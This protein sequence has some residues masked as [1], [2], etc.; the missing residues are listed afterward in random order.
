VIDKY[1]KDNVKMH[2]SKF[3]NLYYGPWPVEADKN[4]KTAMELVCAGREE[5]VVRLHAI[6][7][8]AL[9]SFDPIVRTTL[10]EEFQWQGNQD[11]HA[12]LSLSDCDIIYS[13][14]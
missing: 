8:G 10:E 1:S 5:L 9:R 7:M 14:I 13:V 2:K 6:G 4:P 3:T 11:I 12:F